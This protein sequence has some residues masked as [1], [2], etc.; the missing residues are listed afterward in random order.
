MWWGSGEEGD[1]SICLSSSSRSP[2]SLTI[3]HCLPH[4]CMEVSGR[5][6]NLFILKAHYFLFQTCCFPW[7]SCLGRWHHHPPTQWCRP[8]ALISH[9]A[10]QF[11]CHSDPA[12]SVSKTISAPALSTP[13][14][15]LPPSPIRARATSHRALRLESG[16]RL[17]SWL[18]HVLA[19]VKLC[20]S[21]SPAA[22]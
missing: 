18:Y 12:R 11:T 4:K 17:E 15:L 3:S 5:H 6:P 22:T 2:A 1:A 7:T 8:W 13:A 14:L 20:A 16:P 10:S 19:Q 9:S 21:V